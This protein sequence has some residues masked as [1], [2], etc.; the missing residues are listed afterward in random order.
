MRKTRRGANGSGNIRKRTQVR[1]DGTTRTYWEGRY[2]LGFD[3]KSGKQ[4]QKSVYGKT[5]GEVR[6][7]ITKI[8]SEI[9]MGTHVE[10]TKM[11]VKE[12]YSFW[13]T[14]MIDIKESTAY[15]YQ[16]YIKT[17]VLPYLGSIPM[18]KLDGTRIQKL[19]DSL[20]RPTDD[21]NPLSAKTVKNIHSFLSKSLQQAV[22]LGYIAKNPTSTCKLPKIEKEERL[23]LDENQVADFL[24][25]IK[26]SP[27]ELLYKIALFTGLREGEVLGLTWDCVD[28]EHGTLFVYRQLRK[29]QKKGGKYYFSTPKNGKSRLLKVPPTVL[30]LLKQQQAVLEQQK[31]LARSMWADNN[32]VFPNAIGAFLSYRTV[33]DCYKRIVKK[34]GA[35]KARFHDLR[36]TYAYMALSSGIDVKTVQYNLGH[37]TPDFT[38]RV[39]AHVTAKMKEM[40]SER[41]ERY[42]QDIPCSTAV[43]S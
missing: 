35:P 24:S 21:R 25:A 22:D 16:T 2:S 20:Y 1:K 3:E 31:V 12:W 32:L 38:L 4:I 7:K 14:Y 18:K 5:Q 15:L 19:Y 17:Y 8:L 39:Y 11:T 37:A 9:D 36:H 29:E 13:E 27:H 28:W 6:E 23:P 41:M 26:G 40:G 30:Q 33:Y 42:I 34:I 43:F 10:P